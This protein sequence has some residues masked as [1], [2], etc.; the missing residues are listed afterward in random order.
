MR[1]PAIHL[2]GIPNLSE[3]EAGLEL[4]FSDQGVEVIRDGA[5]LARMRWREIRAVDVPVLKAGLLRRRNVNARLVIQRA[6]GDASFEIPGVTPD[7]LH[8]DL[9]PLVARQR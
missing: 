3:S 7:E 9:A 5:A 2:G 1:V 6:Q 4:H 8:E